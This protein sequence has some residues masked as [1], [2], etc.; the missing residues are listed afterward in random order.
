MIK[1]LCPGLNAIGVL[2]ESN[3]RDTG[4]SEGWCLICCIALHHISHCIIAFLEGFRHVLG[5]HVDS[6]FQDRQ[7]HEAQNQAFC[8]RQSL[9]VHGP[10]WNT[11]KLYE[12]IMQMYSN[13]KGMLLTAALPGYLIHIQ[14]SKSKWHAGS[15]CPSSPPAH[16]VGVKCGAPWTN[17]THW[18]FEH[19]SLDKGEWHEYATLIQPF[20]VGPTLPL[21]MHI[22]YIIYI[23]YIYIIT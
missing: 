23:I 1:K 9:A 22:I 13:I 19:G 16:L 18:R 6:P 10:F 15:G 11:L 21:R 17:K 14:K 20:R 7:N 3:S 5:N 12:H 4:Y 2:Q 8:K